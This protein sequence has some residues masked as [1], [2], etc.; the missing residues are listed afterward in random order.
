MET[1]FI[2]KS[3]HIYILWHYVSLAQCTGAG[4]FGAQP[5]CAPETRACL[6][7]GIITAAIFKQKVGTYGFGKD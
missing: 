6:C 7:I 4:A 2:M 1:S 3:L 5:G